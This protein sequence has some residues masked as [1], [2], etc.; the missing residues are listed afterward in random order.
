MSRAFLA[1]ALASALASLASP[2]ASA[3]DSL[4]V[5]SGDFEAVSQGE[6]QAGGPGYALVERH[7][8]VRLQAG[9]NEVPIAG[10]PR[11]LDP[12]SVVAT[13]PPGAS[14]RGQRFDFA[15][16]GQEELL[17]RALGQTVQVE[18]SVGNERQS[19]TGVL[20]AAGDGLT[21]RL[22]D[23]RIKMLSN[24][25]SFELRQ[26]PSGVVN[27]PTLVLALNAERATG[28]D[29]ILA[30]ATAGMAWRA[31][32]TANLQGQGKQ[33]RMDLDGA[34]MVVNRSGAD[35]NDVM[36]TLV[37]GEPHREQAMVAD[38]MAARAPSPKMMMAAAAP[39]AQASGEYQAYHLPNPGTLQQGS[40]QRLPLVA[41]ARGVTCE[42]R[43]ETSAAF[44]EWRPPYPIIDENF[45]AGDGQPQPVQATVRFNNGKAAGLGIPLPAGRVRLFEGKDFLGEAQLG[46]TPAGKDVALVMGNAFDLSATRTRES[47]SLDRNGRTMTESVRVE[48]NNAKPAAVVVRVNER[49]GRWTAWD[50]VSSSEPIA[51]RD[52][53]SAAFDVPVPAGGKAS[54]SYTV[55]YR[56]AEDV[57]IP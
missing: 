28:G 6:A 22:P 19:Y 38:A 52:A 11:A 53:Q 7:A 13:P 43:Y 16:A 42:R 44:G 3:T 40:V 25:S 29:L 15:L 47:F 18:Q 17:R 9:D 26:L 4:T 51:A 14:L 31:E 57:K 23:G 20:L 8:T 21:L 46:H 37:A 36:L 27:E 10:L 34:A 45:N 39:Q 56:W 41:P 33:C 30:Y 50:M 48:I 24:Y 54:F 1:S 49:L 55:R 12:A 5:Y 32:Y 35:F 2:P